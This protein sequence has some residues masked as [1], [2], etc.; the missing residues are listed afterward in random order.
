MTELVEVLRAIDG[1]LQWI[2]LVLALM[3]FFK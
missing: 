3:L 2:L 1:T